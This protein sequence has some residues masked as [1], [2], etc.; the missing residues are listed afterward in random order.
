MRIPMPDPDVLAQWLGDRSFYAGLIL[1]LLAIGLLLALVRSR[2]ARRG[3][4][5]RPRH[6]GPERRKR[7][8]R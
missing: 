7:K 3:P 4:V 6:A 2:R 5:A 8:S 1:V